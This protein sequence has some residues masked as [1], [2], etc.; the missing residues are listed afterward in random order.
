MHKKLHFVLLL[1]FIFNS[2]FSQEN[3]CPKLVGL[4]VGFGKE[5]TNPDYNFS[6][7]YY[8]L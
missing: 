6:S 5:V 1:I 8:K 3:K 7:Q 2:V 4:Y